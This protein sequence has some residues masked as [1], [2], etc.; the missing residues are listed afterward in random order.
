MS[1]EVSMFNT[2]GAA[3]YLKCS[4]PYIHKLVAS[5]KLRAYIYNDLGKLVEREPDDLRQ[6]QGLSF[7]ESDLR[8]FDLNRVPRGRPAK[9]I[10]RLETD[11]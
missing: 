2:V 7:Y 3:H 6:G 1:Q 4:I 5:N 9:H 10:Q 8:A 11:K